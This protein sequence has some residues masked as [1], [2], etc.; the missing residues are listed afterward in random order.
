M[1]EEIRPA[2]SSGPGRL[3]SL[4][5]IV[6]AVWG[7]VGIYLLQLGIEAGS[8]GR[9]REK[10]VR[11][12]AYFPSG[13]ALRLVTAEYREL[14]ADFVW[15]TAIDYYGR[16]QE[17][18]RRY[19]WLGHIFGILATLDERFT[20]AYHF[21][22]ITLAWDARKP[23]EAIRLLYSGMKANPLEWQLP[24]DAG[25]V[26][27]MLLRDY[28][29]AAKL[30]DVASRLPDAW[31]VVARWAPYV[32]AKGGDYETARRMWRDVYYSTENRKLRELVVRQLKNLKLE[33]GLAV[34]QSA[35]D[36]FR[37][38]VGHAPRSVAELVD[39][40]LVVEVPEEPFGGR[41]YIEDGR[42]RTT[43]PPSGRN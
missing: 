13:K 37:E 43:T 41:F 7:F 40:G 30:F 11:E 17:T 12:L 18:D 16:H 33:E 4:L 25:F 14:A 36:K 19:E 42:V 28:R 6:L 20:G 8:A 24:F 38:E 10:L 2:V 5:P 3:A 23:H 27:Y 22:A 9:R 1:F 21:G 31:S 32:A 26:N 39:R 34:L 35:A 15:L 29:T